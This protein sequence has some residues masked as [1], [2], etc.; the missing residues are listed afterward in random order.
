MRKTHAAYLTIVLALGVALTGC[1]SSDKADGGSSASDRVTV[2]GAAGAKPVVKI[3][4]PLKVEE[5]TSWTTIKGKGPEVTGDAMVLMQLTLANGRTGKTE[6][7][8][9]DSG[10]APIATPLDGNIFPSLVKA[11]TGQPAG[12]RVVVAATGKDTYGDKGAPQLGFKK[13][14]PVV[15]VADILAVP[16]KDAL[17]A[18]EGKAVAPAAGSPKLIEKDGKP[19]GFDFTGAK[20]PK[21]L[22][23]IPLIEGTGPK[24][25]NPGLV[26]VNYLGSVW[27]SDKVFDESYTKEPVTFPLGLSQVIQGWDQGLKDVSRGSRVLVICPPDMGYGAEGSGADIPPNSTLVFV[28]DVL[29]AS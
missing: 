3:K 14:D 4:A 16:D 6:V 1:G 20:K 9:F 22:T 2:T 17:K 12:S 10:Q 11:L 5:T 18:P 7:S 13:G 27:G 28:V 29:G 8:T 26:T 25:S 21:G 15:M 19:T 24:A 23:V